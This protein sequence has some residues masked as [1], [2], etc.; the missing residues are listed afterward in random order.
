NP[1]VIRMDFSSEPAFEEIIIQAR[2]V[3]LEAIKHQAFP[4]A[5][6]VQRLQPQRDLSRSPLFQAMF[7]FQK[8]S[9]L[10]GQDLAA[11]ALGAPG[12][13]V[14]LGNLRLEAA[15]VEQGI[16]QFDLAIAMAETDESITTSIEYSTDLFEEATIE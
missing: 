16:A 13:E 7:V 14:Q 10:A 11:L 4:L 5:T 3:V 6:L 15:P 1:V 8:T 2:R 12:T 9:V